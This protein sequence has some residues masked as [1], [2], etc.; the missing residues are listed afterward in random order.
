M[1]VL[2][3][4]A[5]NRQALS[6]PPGR[7]SKNFEIPLNFLVYRRAVLRAKPAAYLLV[8]AK[9]V[10]HQNFSSS[11]TQQPHLASKMAPRDAAA[12]SKRKLN[13]YKSKDKSSFN[14]KPKFEKRPPPSKS[15]SDE[16]SEENDFENFS[17]DQEDGGASLSKGK[18]QNGGQYSNGNKPSNGEN[19]FERGSFPAH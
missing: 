7:I 17:D 9:S 11:P 14:K 10:Y 15:E 2:G 19:V 13:D 16:V 12:G 1:Q 5:Q 6:T 3:G 18:P 4:V 8:S